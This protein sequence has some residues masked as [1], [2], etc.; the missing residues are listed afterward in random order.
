MAKEVSKGIEHPQTLGGAVAVEE[1]WRDRDIERFP[2]RPSDII[3]D[4][5]KKYSGS[6]DEP[7]IPFKDSGRDDEPEIPYKDS[8]SD[9]EPGIPIKDSDWDDSVKYSRWDDK[10]SKFDDFV[11]TDLR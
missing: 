7:W 8:G 10:D 11:D 2:D 5:G 4:E 9:D 1:R 3:S 6:D